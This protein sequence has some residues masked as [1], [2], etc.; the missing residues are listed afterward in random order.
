MNKKT[1]LI[2][3]IEHCEVHV[4]KNG[5]KADHVEVDHVDQLATGHDNT[6]VRLSGGQALPKAMA[7]DTLRKPGEQINEL[8][9]VPTVERRV[10]A[11]ECHKRETDHAGNETVE[12]TRTIT[13]TEITPALEHKMPTT[14]IVRPHYAPRGRVHPS[15]PSPCPY[16]WAWASFTTCGQEKRG[17]NAN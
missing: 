10:T 2:V 1:Y 6:L 16:C 11:T 12:T 17:N 15:P 3:H 9:N 14:A 13:A 4:S 8:H 5:V 7:K